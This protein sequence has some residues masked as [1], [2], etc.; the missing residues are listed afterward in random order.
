MVLSDTVSI[1]SIDLVTDIREDV[2]TVLV[3]CDMFMLHDTRSVPH[4]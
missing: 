4:G 1:W 2:M 3:T